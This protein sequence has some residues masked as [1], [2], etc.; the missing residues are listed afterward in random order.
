MLYN[1]KRFDSGK[2]GDQSVKEEA[3]LL[4]LPINTQMRQT[5][6]YKVSKTHLYLQDRDINL[7][8]I[9]LDQDSSIFKIE[10]LPVR[11]QEKDLNVQMELTIERNLDLT[12]LER[13]GYTLI[14]VFSDIGGIQSIL[15]S[16]ITILINFFNFQNF[17][18]YMAT[19][20]FKIKPQRKKK[21]D[22]DNLE[23]E[24]L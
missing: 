17:D 12:Q 5:I 1:Q 16:G 14:D 4:W 22:L 9:T 19:R 24:K 23:P 6:P 18:N 3:R 10:P 11:S 15:I 21:D 7:N 2:Y 8:S 20:L 13:S